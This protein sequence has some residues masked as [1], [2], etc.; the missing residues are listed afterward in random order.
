MGARSAQS[1]AIV[2]AGEH[3][4]D[5]TGTRAA[6]RLDVAHGVAGDGHSLHRGRSRAQKGGEDEVGRGASA[7]G[8]DRGEREVDEP[9]TR[10]R[11]GS[12]VA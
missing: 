4:C 10:G 12:P 6:A 1:R 8:V 3:S 2:G 5:E 11:R 7:A 9:P